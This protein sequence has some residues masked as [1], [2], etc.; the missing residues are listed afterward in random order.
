MSPELILGTAQFDTA[1]GIARQ[2][3][4]DI[5][6]CRLL[7]LAT[8]IGVATLDTAP[9]YGNAQEMIGFCNWQGAIH[10]KIPR[11]VNVQDSL[12]NSLL[13]LRRERVE[14]AYF[15]HPDV[16]N[17]DESFFEQTYKA[18][19]PGL[20]ENLGVS[21]YTPGEFNAALS[22]P[23]VSVIQAPINVVDRRV[24][25]EQLREAVLR[26]KHVF[27]RSIF[28]QGALLQEPPGLPQFLSALTPTIHRMEKISMDTG[29]NRMEIL[30]QSVLA[31]RGVSGIIVGAESSEQL[32]EI[33]VAF[34][35]PPLAENVV[36]E[37]ESLQVDSVD[38][39]D[40]RMWPKQ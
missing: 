4:G 22:N 34:N 9:A 33:E 13:Q 6:A 24:T 19:V 40:P 29:L 17:M 16:L 20:A 14:V 27:A 25:D 35:A 26:G 8:S 5:D 15:H 31:R 7:A 28:L 10:T 37:M 23:F 11:D 38:L 32:L 21:T 18:V 2:Q 12:R 39:I 1:Y 36:T 30:I 3:A